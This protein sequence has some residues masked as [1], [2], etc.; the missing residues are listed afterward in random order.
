MITTNEQRA[1]ALGAELAGL[2]YA[3]RRETAPG[4]AIAWLQREETEVLLIDEN[5]VES[6]RWSPLQFVRDTS[7]D[8]RRLVV[9]NDVRGFRLYYAIKAGLVDGLVE[10]AMAGEALARQ[11]MGTAA[12]THAPRRAR[13]GR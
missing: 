12:A 2:G 3:V 4:Q 1:G 5:V 6:E 10:P 11:L 9:A 13:A 8:T 7:P